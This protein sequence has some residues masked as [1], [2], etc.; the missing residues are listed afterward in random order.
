MQ[1]KPPSD[2]G[3]GFA[4]GEDGGREKLPFRLAI[5][6]SPDKGSLFHLE[7]KFLYRLRYAAFIV[8]SGH[9]FRCRL[10]FR[11]GIFHCHGNAC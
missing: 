1:Q 8:I 4:A 11:G 10:D 9:I 6:R 5:T 3:G 2:E 7:T